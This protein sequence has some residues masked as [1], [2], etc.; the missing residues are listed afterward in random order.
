MKKK[1]KNYRKANTES[2]I[3]IKKVAIQSSDESI[4]LYE[5]EQKSL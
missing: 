3:A 4:Q 5:D 1:I 2:K